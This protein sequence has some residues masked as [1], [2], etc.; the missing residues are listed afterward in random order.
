[1]IRAKLKR[2][3]VKCLANFSCELLHHE[4]RGVLVLRHKA[5]WQSAG[6][7]GD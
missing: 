3:V 7:D 4:V 6:S 2:D 1:M 5:G